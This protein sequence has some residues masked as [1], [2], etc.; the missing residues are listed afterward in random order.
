MGILKEGRMLTKKCKKYT[1][2]EETLS[3]NVP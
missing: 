3:H 1:N 2:K